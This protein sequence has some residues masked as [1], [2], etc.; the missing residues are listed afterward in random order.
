MVNIEEANVMD[1]EFEEKLNSSL[2]DGQLPCAIALKIAE[3]LRVTPKKVGEAANKL[4]I[5]IIECQLG[6]FMY[7]GLKQNM[8]IERVNPALEA[9]L[10][11]SLVND[12][13]PCAAAFRVAEKLNLER[14]KVGETADA[15]GIKISG[16]QLG[17]FL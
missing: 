9:E 11:T 15:L 2:V 10:A 16:C 5:T 17:C 8:G 4:N 7:T 3:E 14:G 13:L 1:T 12:K 6:C